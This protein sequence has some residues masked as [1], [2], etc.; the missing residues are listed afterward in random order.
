VRRPVSLAHKSFPLCDDSRAAQTLF[1]PRYL[2]CK[3]LC[4]IACLSPPAKVRCSVY[5][6]HME[7]NFVLVF[8]KTI[9]LAADLMLPRIKNGWLGHHRRPPHW[10]ETLALLLMLRVCVVVYNKNSDVRRR[11]KGRIGLAH[12]QHTFHCYHHV[13]DRGVPNLKFLPWRSMHDTRAFWDTV[14]G[15]G[16]SVPVPNMLSSIHHPMQI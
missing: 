3:S 12:D 15:T 8:L 9:L 14:T 1:S 16:T 13:N 6:F 7:E 4:T 5:L 10:I 11:K 2:F